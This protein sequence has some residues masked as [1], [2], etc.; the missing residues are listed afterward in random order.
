MVID[1]RVEMWPHI[2]NRIESVDEQFS[3]IEFVGRSDDSGVDAW[4]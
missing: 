1:F 3:E 2:Q 4:R